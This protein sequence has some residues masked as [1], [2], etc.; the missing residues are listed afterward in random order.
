M[1]QKVCI[2]I[3]LSIQNIIQL[4]GKEAKKNVLFEGE[5]EGRR[6]REREG[7]RERERERD[8]EIGERLNT[9]RILYGYGTRSKKSCF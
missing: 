3:Y 5:R 4:K 1:R 6:E 9:E 2:F 7:E 8:G